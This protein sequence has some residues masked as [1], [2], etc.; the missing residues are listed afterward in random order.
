MTLPTLLWVL[1]IAAM[2]TPVIALA[3]TSQRRPVLGWILVG[4]VC[5]GGKHLLLRAMPPW[6]DTPLDQD[7][8]FLAKPFG[9]RTLLAAVGEACA[10]THSH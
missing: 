5:F 3:D 8:R 6:A 4:G 7:M 10:R 1:A 9:R 2:T